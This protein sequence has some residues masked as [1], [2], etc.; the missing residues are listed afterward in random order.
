MPSDGAARD[1]PMAHAMPIA[2]LVRAAV[3]AAAAS[4]AGASTSG[5]ATRLADEAAAKL[6]SCVYVVGGLASLPG[7][8]AALRE[9]VDTDNATAAASAAAAALPP[10]ANEAPAR[11]L[12]HL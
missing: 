9:A 12:I 2:S 10:G 8:E 11:S 5:D 6:S 4:A 3:A 1:V 7:F